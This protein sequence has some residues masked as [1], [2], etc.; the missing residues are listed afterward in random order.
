MVEHVP[1]PEVELLALIDIDTLIEALKD[2]DCDVVHVRVM[3]AVGDTELVK[4]MEVDAVVED[5]A[6]TL[7]V[8]E[9]EKD[10]E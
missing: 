7:A 1:V 8:L 6:V 4:E 2:R 5:V 3:E 10:V 9:V